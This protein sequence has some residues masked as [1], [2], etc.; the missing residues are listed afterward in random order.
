MRDACHALAR[1]ARQRIGAL[2]GLPQIAPDSPDWWVQM[3]A[4]PLPKREG[5]MREELQ[6]R[7]F[8]GFRVE[9][10]I[11]DW[12]DWRFVRVSIQ[13]YNTAHDVDR[14]VEGLAS[15]L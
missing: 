12:N 8:D 15:V 3:C 10:P 11:A 5:V 4:V 1:E 6:H 2:T 7:L 14:L 9:V 13:A